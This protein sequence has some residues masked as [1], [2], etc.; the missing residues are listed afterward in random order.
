VSV[1]AVTS[2]CIA[3]AMLTAPNLLQAPNLAA[4]DW[5]THGFG[6]RDSVYPSPITTVKQIHSGIVIEATGA[7]GDRIAEAD[8]WSHS[9][10]AWW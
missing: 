4:F 3:L 2:K 7:G 10:Q 1:H 5:L 8:G 9:N 6:Q